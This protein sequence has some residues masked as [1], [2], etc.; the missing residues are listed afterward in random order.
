MYTRTFILITKHELSDT[1][2]NLVPLRLLLEEAIHADP[3]DLF[4]NNDIELD[5]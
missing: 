2:N 3:E 4:R 5:H 1:M